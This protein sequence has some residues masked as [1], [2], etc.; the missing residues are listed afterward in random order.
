MGPPGWEIGW[1]WW[2]NSSRRE[3]N[4]AGRQMYALRN[5]VGRNESP[6]SIPASTLIHLHV[7]TGDVNLDC[8][9]CS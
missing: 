7:Q 4:E 9:E 8:G 3:G 1:A 5:N 2:G 6:L